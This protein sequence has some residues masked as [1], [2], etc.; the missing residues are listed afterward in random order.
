[1]IKSRVLTPV[2]LSLGSNLGDRRAYIEA[3]EGGLREILVDVRVSR[4]METEP[5]GVA[6]R[7]DAYLNRIVVGLY[8]GSAF[9]L[10]RECLAIE[11]RLGRERVGYR[12]PRTAD[13]DILLFGAEGF[14]APPELVVPHP[15]LLNR[16]FCLDGLM[17][18]DPAILVPVAGGLPA[19]RE[20]R[21]NMG[22][23]VA[24]QKVFFV[25]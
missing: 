21:E 25:P 23:A 4:L 15:E 8:G 7:Q 14:D 10:L 1:M 18:I 3:M 17:D 20:L 22:A 9:G 13:V 16:R 6:G 24:A 19:V 5:V 2:A 12:A 11:S